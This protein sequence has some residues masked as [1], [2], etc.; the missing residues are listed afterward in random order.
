MIAVVVGII[1]T[2]TGAMDMEESAAAGDEWGFRGNAT[3][4]AGSGMM[5]VG[6]AMLLTG[7]GAPL[8]AFLLVAGTIVN[9]VGS[10]ITLFK[11]KSELELWAQHCVFGKDGGDDLAGQIE[12][13]RKA[14]YTAHVRGFIDSNKIQ[15]DQFGERWDITA[16]IAIEPTL[17]TEMSAMKVELV[18]EGDEFR[19]STG[20]DERRRDL[21][22][23][24]EIRDGA[25]EGVTVEIEYAD[26][27]MPARSGSALKE[28]Q[29]QRDEAKDAG[30]HKRHDPSAIL[31]P[32]LLD[33][34]G[35]LRKD[36][37]IE[38]PPRHLKKVNLKV[39]RTSHIN[40]DKIQVVVKLFPDGG[41][42]EGVEVT[43]A[44]GL[45]VMMK[46]GGYRAAEWKRG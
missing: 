20:R 7:V 15:S 17:L 27:V 14:V 34:K 39:A 46:D 3:A 29:R 16:Y 37:K 22:W 33:G 13:L 45:F 41:D 32:V 11:G 24:G 23:E 9:L 2:I 4:T 40:V 36:L 25:T 43:G 10:L 18:G 26:V 19:V 12:E 5:V 31:E 28:A 6:G 21:I 8:G 30:E 1:D 38:N 35:A 44:I 42:G